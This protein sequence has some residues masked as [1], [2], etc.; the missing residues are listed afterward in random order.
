MICKQC[1]Y[2]G[3]ESDFLRGGI[4]LCPKCQSMNI[5]IEKAGAPAV[6]A[7][8]K[9][10]NAAAKAAASVPPKRIDVSPEGKP[11]TIWVGLTGDKS[12][13]HAGA[14]ATL[15]GVPEMPIECWMAACEQLM[16]FTA[17]KSK[18]G[19]EKVLELLVEGAMTNRGRLVKK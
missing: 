17:Q 7:P 19:F 8:P 15:V 9:N 1:A 6:T 14:E 4:Y 13:P 11:V 2:K 5:R 16:V 12:D 3:E 18:E 10:G